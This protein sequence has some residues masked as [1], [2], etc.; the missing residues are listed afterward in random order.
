MRHGG[1]MGTQLFWDASSNF[2]DGA[3]DVVSSAKAA[4]ACNLSL[5]QELLPGEERFY[6][7]DMLAARARELDAWSQFKVYSPMEP[8]ECDEEVVG[9][10]WVLTWKVADG[11]KTV[12]ACLVAKGYQDP[13]LEDGLVGT[14]GCVSLRP[15]HL[16]VFSLAALRGWRLWSLDIKNAF[17]QADGFGRD[18]FIQFPL[19][20]LP[21][22]SRRVWKLN[23]PAF[24]LN[25]APVAFHGSLKRYLVNDVDSLKAADLR[26]EA[27]KFDPCLVCVY[28]RSGPAVGVI[29]T[30]SDDFLGCGVQ[31]IS[32]KMG[33]CLATRFG[34]VSAQKD[35]FTHIGMDVLKKDDGS[36]EIT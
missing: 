5:G 20:W 2:S 12:K 36:A 13:D 33:T 22:D 14:S 27:P 26:S 23:A 4:D 24:G 34:H 17:P 21:G 25:D 11:V 15:S 29:T 31:D 6:E 3:I 10:R 19:E 18:L 28:R 7:K 30:H 32:Q 16:Q 9:T 35:N 8:G 1:K